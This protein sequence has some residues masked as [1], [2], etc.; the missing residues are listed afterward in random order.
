MKRFANLVA[1]VSVCALGVLGG[2][3]SGS[4]DG[5]TPV[6]LDK[7]PQEFANALCDT[8]AP[9]CKA[10]S[11]PYVE[12]TCKSAASDQWAQVIAQSSAAHT[13]YDPDAAGRCIAAIKKVLAS[14]TETPGDGTAVCDKVF[15]GTIAVG[16]ACTTSKDCVSPAIC[17]RDFNNPS[18][19]AA[20]V[21]AAPPSSAAHAHEGEACSGN[22]FTLSNSSSV[23]CENFGTSGGPTVAGSCYVSDGLFCND[24]QTC[25]KFAKIGE[26]CSTGGCVDGAYCNAGVCAAQIDSG[27]CA[28]A[29]DACSAKSYC[30]LGQCFAKKQDHFG[31]AQSEECASGICA[32]PSTGSGQGT[33]GA[34]SIGTPQFC[35]GHPFGQQP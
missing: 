13:T 22:C 10:A 17:A 4:D 33:C 24:T 6:T 11:V 26:T 30:D 31:C 25:A 12:S 3:C 21:C 28:Q 9:C 1:A 29:Q 27:S 15:L 5:V 8:V 20:G 32:P 7:Y 23:E 35:S 19:N 16:G 14:C 2:G 18:L 34:P